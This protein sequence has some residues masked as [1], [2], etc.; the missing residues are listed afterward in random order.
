MSVIKK[1]WDAEENK[2][3]EDARAR[4]LVQKCKVS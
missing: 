2:D 1:L 4:A 3:T